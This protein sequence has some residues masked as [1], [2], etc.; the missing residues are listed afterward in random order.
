VFVVTVFSQSV[1]SYIVP[2][3]ALIEVLLGQKWATQLWP[4]C[5][6]TTSTM[7]EAGALKLYPQSHPEQSRVP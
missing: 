5:G 1:L 6:A 3:K 4:L 7:A 2:S